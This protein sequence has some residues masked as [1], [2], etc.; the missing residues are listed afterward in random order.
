[1]AVVRI[2]GE[3]RVLEGPDDMT[4]LWALR[5]L[6]GLT[7][8]KYGCGVGLCGACT[9]HV[10]GVAERS[11]MLTIADVAGKEVTTIE[12]LSPTGDHPVQAAWRELNVPQCGF[13][14]AGQIMQ[15]ASLLA[16]KPNPTDQEILSEMEGNVCRCGCYERIVAAVRLAAT[17][18]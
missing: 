8:T 18:S 13:C 12:G 7:G 2:S 1:M 17:G 10:D 6:A 16:A 9:V 4:L 15:A 5:D 3:D 14:Q 11:C